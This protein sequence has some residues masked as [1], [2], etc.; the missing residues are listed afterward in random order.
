MWKNIE[1]GNKG[2][3]ASHRY[4]PSLTGVFQWLLSFCRTAFWRSG[5]GPG[6][7]G[8]AD[9]RQGCV[10]VVRSVV[11]HVPE[12][13]EAHLPRQAVTPGS[14]RERVRAEGGARAHR[15]VRHPRAASGGEGFQ[16][17]RRG[18]VEE[19]GFEEEKGEGCGEDGAEEGGEGDDGRRGVDV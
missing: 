16:T 19:G 7:S 4:P 9:A 11:R 15:Q 17:E 14:R 5:A 8:A 2:R 18:Q 6:S 1:R 13:H 3:A 12:R 10:Q